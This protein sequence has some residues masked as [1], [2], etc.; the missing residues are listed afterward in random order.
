MT[1]FKCI[2]GSAP[3]PIETPSLAL[4]YQNGTSGVTTYTVEN[5]GVFLIAVTFSLAGNGSITLPAG[6]TAM[7]SGD[8]I[9]VDEQGREKGTRISVVSL[10]AGD[11]IT[12]STTAGA[13]NAI[14]KI[15]LELPFAVSTLVDSHTVSDGIMNYT[16][17]TGSGDVFCLVTVWA[18]L[19]NGTNL[20]D[21]TSAAIDS[22]M[23]AGFAGVNTLFRAFICDADDFPTISARGYDGGGVVAVVL[24]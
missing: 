5:D 9:T 23:V 17:S 2:G 16:L 8:Y 1:W 14:S 22:E 21:Y 4:K 3:A 10:E 24:Q 7:Y 11:V 19:N 6:R 12:M 15:V 18:R 20:Y 13:W